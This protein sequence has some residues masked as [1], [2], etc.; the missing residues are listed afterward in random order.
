MA[1]QQIPQSL[2]CVVGNVIPDQFI[3]T[4]V[5]QDILKTR[6]GD[7]SHAI[8]C[9]IVRYAVQHYAR[10][11][12]MLQEIKGQK[13]IIR[14]FCPDHMIH[15][16]RKIPDHVQPVFSG[17]LHQISFMLNSIGFHRETGQ[18]L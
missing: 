15:A 9:Q 10:L 2:K 17:N 1:L 8:F 5:V 12:L 16:F 6:H 11:W 4:V 13:Y 18:N 3:I 14:P 7:Q